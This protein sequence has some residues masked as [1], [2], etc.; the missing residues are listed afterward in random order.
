[1]AKPLV[2]VMPISAALAVSQ[3]SVRS[4]QASRSSAGVEFK[5]I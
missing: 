2:S 5:T 4:S 1:M 3:D